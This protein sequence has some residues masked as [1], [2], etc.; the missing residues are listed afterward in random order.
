[1]SSALWGAQSLVS[2]EAFLR[3]SWSGFGLATICIIG[4]LA[5][6]LKVFKRL[7]IDDYSVLLAWC[8]S[9]IFSVVWQIQSEHV[10]AAILRM[11]GRVPMDS[12]YLLYFND[13]IIVQSPSTIC[14]NLG[15]WFVK[16]S[17]MFFFWKMSNQIRKQ[18]LLWWAVM[19]YVSITLPI[20]LAMAPWS[21]FDSRRGLVTLVE[22][23]SNSDMG[24]FIMV[25]FKVQAVLD[26][27]TE[28]AILTI[29]FTILWQ[30]RLD[31][32][33]KFGLGA[34][35]ALT[36]SIIL[37]VITRTIIVQMTAVGPYVD[38]MSVYLWYKI[39]L[40]T[41]IIVAC[42]ASYRAL[43]TTQRP[44][45]PLLYSSHGS[46]AKPLRNN[47]SDSILLRSLTGGNE[48]PAI[49]GKIHVKSEYVVTNDIAVLD[50]VV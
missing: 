7:F 41:A 10:Y 8:C 14:Q 35:F 18:R 4:R 1:M 17:F 38:I 21:C 11:I 39:E 27:T 33:R 48:L 16:F 37:C 24:R 36:V 9:L 12:S 42:L 44:H 22:R 49:P 32:R 19:T 47:K 15:L 43:F 20:A 3:V 28:V 2:R 50:R 5:T 45:R 31:F 29:P 23:C 25:A 34:L 46:S 6:R 13:F 30:V 26:I 40:D